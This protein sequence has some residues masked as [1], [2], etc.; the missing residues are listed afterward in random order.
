MLERYLRMGGLVQSSHP[1]IGTRKASGD[2]EYVQ[3]FVFL[4][5]FTNIFI[6]VHT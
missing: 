1:K 4:L 3:F 2:Y 6:G 5:R